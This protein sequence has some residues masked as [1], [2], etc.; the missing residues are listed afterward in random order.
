MKK[1]KEL[2][3]FIPSIE[4]GGVEKNLY[5]ITNYLSTKIDNICLI[6]ANTNKKKEF[7]KKI[8][9]ISPNSLFWKNRSRRIKTIICIYLLIKKL[10]FEKKKYL[11][12]SFQANIYAL[13]ISKIFNLNT[14]VRSNTSPSGWSNNK[15][16]KLFFIHFFKK[17]KAIIV[18]SVHFKHEM[19]KKIKVDT[20][21]I[22]NPLN[23][24]EI[25]KKSKIKIK[26][27]LF[28]KNILNIINVARLTE[29]KDHIT[30]LKAINLIKDKIKL[31]FFIIGKGK[32]INNI[33]NYVKDNKLKKY[34]KYLGYKKNP[35]P[36]IKKSKIFILSSLYEGL[37]NVLLE[38]IA[39]KTSVISSNCPTGPREILMNTKYGDLF[40]VN[41]YKKLAEIILKFKKN[42]TKINS[43]YL[44]LK[45][46]DFKKN[47]ETYL[48]II[49][50]FL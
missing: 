24:S 18:N 47:C 12:L 4:D 40:P 20:I 46:F 10:I 32:E 13:I 16:K 2:I 45:R 3:I 41:D 6:T 49:N 48:N 43:A 50:K 34:V 35:Y 17:A 1:K 37:P 27:S 30:I 7:S 29:Q 15:I 14:I 22:Y 42:P 19:K 23:I 5:L 38:A 9:F 25:K 39:L 8:N 21:C 33:R 44:S 26:S 31:K 28:N 36:Y 11:I